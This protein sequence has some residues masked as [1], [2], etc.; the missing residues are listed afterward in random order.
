MKKIIDG[1]HVG[2]VA[3][4]DNVRPTGKSNVRVAGTRRKKSMDEVTWRWNMAKGATVVA[5]SGRKSSGT[6]SIQTQ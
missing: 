1:I 2:K 5:A 4:K 3:V 6:P